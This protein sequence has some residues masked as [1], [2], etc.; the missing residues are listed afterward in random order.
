MQTNAHAVRQ[1]DWQQ[2]AARLADDL[3][4]AGL[5]CKHI[6]SLPNDS[7]HEPAQTQAAALLSVF[8]LQCMSNCKG[9]FLLAKHMFR[10]CE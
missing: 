2:Q 1:T 5:H 10:A 7:A 3:A 4:V 8:L 9:L 6:L